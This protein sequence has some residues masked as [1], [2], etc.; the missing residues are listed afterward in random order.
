MSTSPLVFTGISSYSADFQTILSRAVSIAQLPVKALQKDQ[1]DILAKKTALGNVQTAVAGLASTLK[2]LGGLGPTKSLV[3]SSSNYSLANV[4]MTGGAV[5]AQP[6]VYSLGEIT[7]LALRAS[8]VSGD[9]ADPATTAVTGAEKYLQLAIGS[10]VHDIN[11]T[12]ETNNLYGLRDAINA[13]NAGVSASVIQTGG[14][15]PEYRLSISANNTGQNRIELRTT[16]DQSATNILPTVNEGADAVFK[17]DGQAVQRKSNIIT[18]VIPGVT[19]T[20]TGKTTGTETAQIQITSSRAPVLSALQELADSYNAVAAQLDSHSGKD[21]GILGGDSLLYDIRGELQ[22]LTSYQSAGAVSSIRDLGLALDNDGTLTFDST[23]IETMTN[24]EANSAFA[25]VGSTSTGL[26]AFWSRL[27]NYSDEDLGL[28]ENQQKSYNTTND[29]LSTQIDALNDRIENMRSTLQAKLQ[30]ADV[31]LASLER[32]QN[33]LTANIQ[34]L[35]L[36]L[37]GKNKEA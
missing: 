33:V 20:L 11:L 12:D 4:T 1:Q 10:E 15:T 5:T 17:I 30:A 7:S 27:N 22:A 34:S 14:Q 23:V 16:A 21:A 35:N 25:F 31:L 9:Y 28:F 36:T 2:K 24:D 8:S 29:S 26:G 13:A 18:D 19:I 6:G 37:Y 3:A 32:Q